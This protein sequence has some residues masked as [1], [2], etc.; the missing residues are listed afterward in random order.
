MKRIAILG[1]F[2]VR[3]TSG[4]CK[5]GALLGAVYCFSIVCLELILHAITSPDPNSDPGLFVASIL[6]RFG[7]GLLAGV[8]GGFF[9]FLLGIAAGFV[10]GWLLGPLTILAYYPPKEYRYYRLVTGLI[11]ALAAAT[12]TYVLLLYVLPGILT[13]VPPYGRTTSPWALLLS[14]VPVAGF[15]AWWANRFVARWYQHAL[16]A[17]QAVAASRGPQTPGNAYEVQG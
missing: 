2:I 3:H 16:P 7:F 11:S 5:V 6:E 15:G 12:T 13:T 14:P 1:Q 17:Q 9:G 4:V 10:N 8:I